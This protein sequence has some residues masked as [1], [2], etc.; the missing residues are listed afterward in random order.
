MMCEAVGVFLAFG[1]LVSVRIFCSFS[2]TTL[3]PFNPPAEHA[4]NKVAK[5]GTFNSSLELD[6]GADKTSHL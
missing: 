2:S 6:S 1:W 4:D 3:T 5:C